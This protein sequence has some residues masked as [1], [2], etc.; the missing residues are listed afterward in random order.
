MSFTVAKIE[1]IVVASTTRLYMP[2]YCHGCLCSGGM[3]GVVAAVGLQANSAAIAICV[4]LL[5][6]THGHNMIKC[7]R[8]TIIKPGR[9]QWQAKNDETHFKISG[10]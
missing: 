3:M 5:V 10:S 9:C 6:M 8:K 4:C 7:S 2:I 1:V